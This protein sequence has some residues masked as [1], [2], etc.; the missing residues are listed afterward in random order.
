MAAAAVAAGV[1]IVGFLIARGVFG[2]PV[3]VPKNGGLV[4]ASEGWYAVASA[5]AAL[6]ATAVM[7]LLLLYAPSPLTFFRWIVGLATVAVTVAP[8]TTTAE[9]DAKVAAACINLAIGVA[10][11]STVLNVVRG[12][13]GPRMVG[14]GGGGS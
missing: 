8:F 3:L 12:S 4:N 2:A 6:A 11:M 9:L 14:Y 10:V 13:T 7:H 5:A 1:A